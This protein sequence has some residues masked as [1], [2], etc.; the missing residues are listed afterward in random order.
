MVCARPRTINTGI[1]LVARF[2]EVIREPY[3][4]R[5]A[6]KVEDISVLNICIDT[7]CRDLNIYRDLSI[8]YCVRPRDRSAQDYIQTVQPEM[9]ALDEDAG[10]IRNLA[11]GILR[12]NSESGA[13]SLAAKTLDHHLAIIGRELDIWSTP[14]TAALG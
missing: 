9:G 3:A 13:V 4:P 5:E 11:E 10:K 8:L 7:R 14:N 1:A 6:C 12:C 2:G